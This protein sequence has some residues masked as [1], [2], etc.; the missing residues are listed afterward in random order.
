[1]SEFSVKPLFDRLIIKQ[2]EAITKTSGGIIIPNGS[3]DKP[4]RGIVMAVGQGKRDEPMTIKV[5]D[6]V[7]I[8]SFS[9]TNIEVD[10]EMYIMCRQDDIM[11]ILM[12]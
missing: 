3:V 8:G 12:D 6:K 9:G 2:E 1:M 5:G 4:H 10:G 11:A 7:I